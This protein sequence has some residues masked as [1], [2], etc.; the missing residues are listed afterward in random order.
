MNKS[1]RILVWNK[2]GKKCSY[3][4]NPLEYKDMEVDHLIPQRLGWWYRNTDKIIK[5]GLTGTVD[6]FKNLMPS[7]HRC[8]HYKRAYLLE[9]FRALMLSIHKR[10]L[11]Q[12]ICKVAKDYGIL[13]L[14]EWGGLFYFEKRMRRTKK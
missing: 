2:Y 11:Q 3:C 10:I 6:D 9:S 8:N 1:Q 4:G 14:T 12:Y 7:C 5:Y 13:Y